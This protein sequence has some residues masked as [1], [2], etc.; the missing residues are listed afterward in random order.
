MRGGVERPDAA[1]PGRVDR[2]PG[3]VVGHL[4]EQVPDRRAAEGQF[5]DEPTGAEPPSGRRRRERGRDRGRQAQAVHAAVDRQRRP[6]DRRRRR[7]GQVGDRGGH[8]FGGDQ[9]PHRLPRL[10]RRALGG[11]VVRLASSRPTHGVSAVPGLTQFTRMPSWTWSAAIASVSDSTAP[12][13]AEYSARCGSPAV[14]AIEQVLTIAACSEARR[15][16]S[17][18]RV[19]RTMPTT[20]TSNT[21]CHSS[22]GLSAT[23]PIEPMPA[24][25][26]RMSRPPRRPAAVSTASRTDASS[27]TSAGHAGELVTRLEVE[28]G[29]LRAAAREEPRGGQP[30]PRPAAGHERGQPGQFWHVIS[31]SRLSPPPAAGR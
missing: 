25:F 3:V 15:Y 18:A 5:G 31:P 9:P 6:G 14:A 8:L 17:A 19:T 10:Q 20:L 7:A 2:G 13:V 12:L 23:V 21:R 16:G 26:T 29:H 22:S 24:L 1:V 4:G 30:D 11:R 28:H 27:A